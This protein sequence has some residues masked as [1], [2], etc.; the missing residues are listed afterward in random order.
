MHNNNDISLKQLLLK[1]NDYRYF[2]QKRWKLLVAV[3]LV[4]C[5]GLVLS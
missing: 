3:A 2:Y 1:L 5:I 4:F